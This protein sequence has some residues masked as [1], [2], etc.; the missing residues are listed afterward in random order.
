MPSHEYVPL[1]DIDDESA[2]GGPKETK[3]HALD[4]ADEVNSSDDQA[5]FDYIEPTEYE[6]KTLRRVS[7]NIPWA[8]Y[9]I[10]FVEFG[11]RFSYYGTTAVCMYSRSII[12]HAATDGSSVVNFIQQPLP[13]GSS[14]G[15]SGTYGQAGALGQGQ[16]VSLMLFELDFED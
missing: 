1:D 7:G 5:K 9:T 3:S 12:F 6:L 11:E 8:A 14:T 4:T 2:F 15:A 16:R 13:P 10:A